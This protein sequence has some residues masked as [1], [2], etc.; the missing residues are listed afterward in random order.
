MVNHDGDIKKMVQQW[1]LIKKGFVLYKFCNIIAY[2]LYQ[3][4][5]GYANEYC[6]TR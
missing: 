3:S 2:Q 4:L 5:F 1:E 6:M